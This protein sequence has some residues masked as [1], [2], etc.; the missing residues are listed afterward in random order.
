MK[1][2][3]IEHVNL[4]SR[5]FAVTLVS[6][7]VFY[8][9]WGMS[10]PKEDERIGKLHHNHDVFNRAYEKYY[11]LPNTSET[12]K[13]TL[14]KMNLIATRIIKKI[15]EDK[16]KIELANDFI[17]CQEKV[18]YLIK[19]LYDVSEIQIT[20]MEYIKTEIIEKLHQLEAEY[21]TQYLKIFK[22]DFQDMQ[23]KI[24]EMNSL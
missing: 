14:K 21:E 4:Y 11:T 22:S 10:S 15:T 24:H 13:E 5:L 7:F 17:N 6:F 18:I 12:L 23:I 3:R 8:V 9:Y 19:S 2:Y 16:Q 20:E 1:H